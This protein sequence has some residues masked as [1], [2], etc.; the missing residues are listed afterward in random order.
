MELTS[1]LTLGGIPTVYLCDREYPVAPV[2]AAE[3]HRQFWNQGVATVLLLRDPEKVRVFSSMTAPV[4]PSGATQAEI[5]RRLIEDLKHAALASWA[6]SFYIRLATGQYYSGDNESKF[7]PQEGVDAY[8]IDNLGAVR[9][10]LTEGSAPLEPSLAHAFLGR[11]LFTCYLCDRGIIEL[12]D[13]F[14]N[15]T[16]RLSA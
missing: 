7:D 2:D 16:W 9:D 14:R 8:L 6:E 1:V 4:N 11:V 10:E 15:R 5:D 13:Y 3:I 12:S